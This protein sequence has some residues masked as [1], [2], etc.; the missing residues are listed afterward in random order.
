[1]KTGKSQPRTRGLPEEGSPEDGTSAAGP[2]KGHL[3]ADS[4]RAWA[5]RAQGATARFLCTTLS[6]SP[7][8]PLLAGGPGAKGATRPRDREQTGLQRKNVSAIKDAISSRFGDRGCSWQATPTQV[9]QKPSVGETWPRQTCSQLLES[10]REDI[11]TVL[12]SEIQKESKIKRHD[13]DLNENKMP[14]SSEVLDENPFLRRIPGRTWWIRFSFPQSTK[15]P[16]LGSRPRSNP[17]LGAR[18]TTYHFN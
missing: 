16:H 2:P 4:E 7:G 9:R 13:R 5:H 14:I 3:G 10:G 1:M 11:R 15:R 18:P 8:S 17:E 6:V 12:S